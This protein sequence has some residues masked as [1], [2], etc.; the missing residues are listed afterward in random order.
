MDDVILPVQANI[1]QIVAVFEHNNICHKRRRKTRKRDV[2]AVQ[3]V[4]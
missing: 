4:S 3:A 2:F 1:R